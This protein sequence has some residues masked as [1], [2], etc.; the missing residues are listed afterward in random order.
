M[1]TLH[2]APDTACLVPK[3]STVL[4]LHLW[5]EEKEEVSESAQ[6]P[7]EQ[8]DTFTDVEY[9]LWRRDRNMGLAVCQEID[10]WL[11]FPIAH[12]SWGWGWGGD[13]GERLGGQSVKTETQMERSGPKPGWTGH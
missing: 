10:D 13:L 9:G 3:G 6:I 11:V 4:A 5:G 1:P 8:D 7:S 2:G 12:V